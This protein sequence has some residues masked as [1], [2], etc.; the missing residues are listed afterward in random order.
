MI[1][2]IVAITKR[3][4][5]VIEENDDYFHVNSEINPVVTEIVESDENVSLLGY[6][7]VK[8]MNYRLRMLSIIVDII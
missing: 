4:N 8:R 6:C 7:T 1:D 5:G 3:I 2:H